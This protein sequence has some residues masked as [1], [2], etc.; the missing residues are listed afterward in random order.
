[1]LLLRVERVIGK[2]C[3]AK[4]ATRDVLQSSGANAL[5]NYRQTIEEP[6]LHE[7][8]TVTAAA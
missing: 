8:I 1:M 3:D 6:D 2:Q 4:L 7:G 5:M